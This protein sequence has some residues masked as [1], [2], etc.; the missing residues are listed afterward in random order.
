MTAG[1]IERVE[2]YLHFLCE[3]LEGRELGTAGNRAAVDYFARTMESFGYQVDLDPFECLGWIDRGSRL[4]YD[5][6]VFKLHTGPYSKPCDIRAALVVAETVEQ[7]RQVPAEGCV[8]LARGELT[9]GQLM[10]R[11]FPFYRSDAHQ[12]IF[13]TLERLRPAVVL[14][15]TGTDPALAGG[16]TPFPW[17]EDGDFEIPNAYLGLEQGE[18][19]ASHAGREVL[20]HI[21]SARAPESGSN[22]SASCGRGPRLVICAHID[23]KRGTPGAIDNGTGIAAL[24]L[25]AEMLAEEQT[26]PIEFTALNGEENYAASGQVRYID[27]NRGRFEQIRLAINL[28]GVGYKDGGTDY[29]LYNMPTDLEAGLRLILSGRSNLSE[30]PAWYQSD[31][32]LFIQNG[33]PALALTSQRFEHIWGQIAHTEL[34]RTELV[35]PRRVVEVSELLRDIALHFQTT[36]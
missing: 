26:L 30:G 36:R 33:R 24:L 3:E 19:L 10:P 8:L 1:D 5:T 16:L 31:H 2:A 28:D 17:I 34:D 32:S 29:S 27:R 25:T 18:R 20:V 9:A 21:D 22:V 11:N 13:C 4:H 12:E 7:L 14:A 15:A 23:T 6:Q 35:E